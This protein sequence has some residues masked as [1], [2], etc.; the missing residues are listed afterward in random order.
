MDLIGMTEIPV[1]ICSEDSY[2]VAS[3]INNMTVKTQPTD[4]DKI[5]IIQEIVAEH[6]DM[7]RI[8]NAFSEGR[9]GR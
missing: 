1:V 5:P 9:Q 7:D 6:T 2:T 8:R 4:K 3:K